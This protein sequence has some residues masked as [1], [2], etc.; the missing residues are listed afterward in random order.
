LFEFLPL[1]HV[2][3]LWYR[4][5]HCCLP[6]LWPA[7]S[8]GWSYWSGSR[9]RAPGCGDFLLRIEGADRRVNLVVDALLAQF[10]GPDRAWDLAGSALDPAEE[11]LPG[12]PL[13]RL[14]NSCRVRP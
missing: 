11:L 9:S 8:S 7:A 2:R 5:E 14:R 1:C 13:I 3:V 12:Q 10:G 6:A 4:R